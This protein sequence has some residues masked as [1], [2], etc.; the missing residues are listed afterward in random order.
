MAKNLGCWDK[1]PNSGYKRYT[2][3]LLTR[4]V[5]FS[6]V[7]RPDLRLAFLGTDHHVVKLTIELNFLDP[8]EAQFHKRWR[9][10]GQTAGFPFCSAEFR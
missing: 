9:V 5:V 1:M 3:N 2:K 6:T 7:Y 8:S 4:L 10:L